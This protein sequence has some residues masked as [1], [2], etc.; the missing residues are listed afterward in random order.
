V[1]TLTISITFFTLG[2]NRSCES[3]PPSRPVTPKLISGVTGSRV[4]Y[5]LAVDAVTSIPTFAFEP[6]KTHVIELENLVEEGRRR[7]RLIGGPV[8]RFAF[9]RALMTWREATELLPVGP[10]VQGVVTTITPFGFFVDLDVPFA[11]LVHRPSESVIGGLRSG[12]CVSLTVVGFVHQ[13]FQLSV[14]LS[15]IEDT[16]LAASLEIFYPLPKLVD[17]SNAQL[18]AIMSLTVSLADPRRSN[19]TPRSA[20]GNVIAQAKNALATVPGL[21]DPC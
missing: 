15:E 12:H 9:D 16:T 19:Q 3:T 6:V 14:R 11:G 4:D 10:A 21:S 8:N 5:A 13:T 18:M 1:A 17:P 20:N 2:L 7:F